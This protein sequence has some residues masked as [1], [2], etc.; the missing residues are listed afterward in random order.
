M[1]GV[2]VAM[3]VVC[4]CLSVCVFMAEGRWGGCGQLVARLARGTL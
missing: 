3:F 4:F 2:E 1:S